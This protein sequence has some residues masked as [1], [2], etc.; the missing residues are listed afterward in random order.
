MTKIGTTLTCGPY[1][2]AT[3]YELVA[4]AAGANT[5]YVDYGTNQ[6]ETGVIG[7]LYTGVDQTT[8]RGTVGTGYND[9]SR[10]QSATCTTVAGDTV[11]G[12]IFIGTDFSGFS[13]SQTVR[14]SWA[15]IAAGYELASVGDKTASGTSTTVNWNTTYTCPWGAFAIPLKAASAGGGSYTLTADGG[16]FV[17]TGSSAGTLFNR[18]LS[19]GSGSFVLTGT[20]ALRDLSMAAD[21]ASFVLTGADATLT[22]NTSSGGTVNG[23][24]LTATLSLISG[25]VNAGALVSG[26]TVSTTLSLLSGSVNA[27]AAVSG[28]T[29][30]STMSLIAGSVNAGSLVSGT[31]LITDLS[32]VAGS[33]SAIQNAT[34]NGYVFITNMSLISGNAF[35][36]GT[37]KVYN[38]LLFSP[39]QPLIKPLIEKIINDD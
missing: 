24:T 28:Q 4:P 9:N 35:T 38:R 25:S 13:D 6:D 12:A 2:K 32:L 14:Q 29:V 39:V 19:A 22:Y 1:W 33:A 36:D 20:D 18:V 10:P 11:V 26:S 7:V 31:T 23:Q 17:L 34:V 15:E 21:S 8:P 37:V 30:S 27:G 16:S 5:L 3:L